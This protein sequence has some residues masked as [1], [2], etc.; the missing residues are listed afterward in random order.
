MPTLTVSPKT[1]TGVRF[2]SVRQASLRIEASGPIDIYVVSED[3][4]P[5][6]SKRHQIYTA[7]YPQQTQFETNLS[8]APDMRKPW[9]VVFKN[10]S[11][12]VIA[13]HYE[14]YH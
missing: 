10:S 8:F 5:E 4:Y 13:V 7:K 1:Y 6:F 3:D 9:Y 12:Q 2:D 14:V 11:D